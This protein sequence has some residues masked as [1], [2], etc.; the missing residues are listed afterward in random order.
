MCGTPIYLAPEC[1]AGEAFTASRDVYAWGSMAKGP[2]SGRLGSATAHCLGLLGAAAPR[3]RSLHRSR[4]ALGGQAVNWPLLGRTRVHSGEGKRLRHQWQ[5]VPK[6][7]DVTAFRRF[8]HPGGASSSV[9]W[10]SRRSRPPTA[11]WRPAGTGTS[12]T[13]GQGGAQRGHGFTALLV[14]D[15]TKERAPERPT[16]AQVISRLCDECCAH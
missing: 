14:V 12:G 5:P 10:C 6:P 8:D 2:S 9:R 13:R 4:S 1:A 7:A 16:A 11:A 3:G 15:C